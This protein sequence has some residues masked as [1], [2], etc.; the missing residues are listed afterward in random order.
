MSLFGWKERKSPVRPRPRRARLEIEVLEDRTV[1]AVFNVAAGDVSTLIADIGQAN[2]NGQSNT[3]N[4]AAG[5]YALTTANNNWY[6]PNGLP[7]ITSSLTINGNGAVLV[8]D[9]SLGLNTP[10]RFFYIAGSPAT[11]QAPGSLTLENLTLEGGVVQGGNSNTGGG[12]LGAGGA[13]QSGRLD[14]QRRD[15]DAEH[16]PGRQQRNRQRGRRRRHRAGRARR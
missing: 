15:G 9:S 8:R 12:G 5:T 1:P 2:S 14:A 13:V 7:A 16:G 6:G 11:G 10:F 3:I 4:L